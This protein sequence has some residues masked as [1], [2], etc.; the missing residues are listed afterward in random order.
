MI[1][2]DFSVTSGRGLGAPW[3]SFYETRNALRRIGPDLAVEA[4]MRV[5]I[6]DISENSSVQIQK[7]LVSAGGHLDGTCLFRHAC[8][9]EFPAN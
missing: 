1:V 2:I 8:V 7:A 3:H 9:P 5:P 4:H 6:P